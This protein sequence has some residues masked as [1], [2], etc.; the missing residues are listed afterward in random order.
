VEE[1]R[2]FS[3]PTDF[4]RENKIDNHRRLCIG[5]GRIL[6]LPRHMISCQHIPNSQIEFYFSMGGAFFISGQRD[7]ESTWIT[8]R[9]RLTSWD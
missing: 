7:I 5:L 3:G 6:R 9:S 2:Q 8:M 1:T 4:R